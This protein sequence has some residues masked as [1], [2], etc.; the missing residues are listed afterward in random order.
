MDINQILLDKENAL[1]FAKTEVALLEKQIDNLRASLA[2][3]S[4]QTE[5]EK[6]LH[7]KAGKVVVT[8]TASYAPLLSAEIP[9]TGSGTGVA[10]N[11]RQRN[12]KGS[13]KAIALDVL[14]AINQTLD[15]IEN[16]INAKAY[17]PVSRAS[18]RTLLMYLKQDGLV[19]SDQ[20]G[21][22]RL[23]SKGENPAGAGFS[24]AT[25]SVQDEL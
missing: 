5:F 1:A 9:S 15:Q 3:M 11:Q 16:N 8:P 24:S 23:A 14:T 12:A 13:V 2:M 17:K 20:P 19:I 22:F 10:E 21:V 25:K 6:M 4:E 7:E 18:I